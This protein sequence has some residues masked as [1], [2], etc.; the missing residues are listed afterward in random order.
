MFPFVAVF[1]QTAMAEQH[2]H[3][4]AHV[5]TMFSRLQH[6]LNCRIMEHVQ[7]LPSLNTIQRSIRTLKTCLENILDSYYETGLYTLKFHQLDRFLEEFESLGCLE[8]L[9]TSEY[10]RF[11]LLLKRVYR[12]F[13]QHRTSAVEETASALAMNA[14]NKKQ[15]LH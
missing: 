5:H 4:K 9:S 6:L 8:L 7:I 11:R 10:E 14:H 1:V 3:H 15:E 13:S 12:P 2:R